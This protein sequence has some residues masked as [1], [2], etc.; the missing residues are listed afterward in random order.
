MAPSYRVMFSGYAPV[1][2]A[3]FKPLYDRLVARDDIDMV[4]TGGLRTKNESGEYEYDAAGMFAPFGIDPSTVVPVSDIGD[5]TCD[6]LFAANTKM[7]APDEVR[8]KIQIFHGISFRNRAVRAENAHADYYFIVGPYMRRRF[9]DAGIMNEDDPRA[10]PIGFMKTDR[11]LDG[12]LD[13]SALLEQ[14]GFD[15]SRPVVVYAPTGQKRNSLET[16]GEEVIRRLRDSGEV[17]ILV[18]PHDHPKNKT[19]DWFDHLS[20][21]EDAHTRITRDPD[22]IPMLYMADLL[23]TD[24]SSVS[25]EYALMD[26]PMVFL[27]VPKL[28]AKSSKQEASM[29]DLDTWGRKGGDLVEQPEDVVNVVTHA[30]A[31]PQ[32]HADVR[33]AMVDDLFFHPGAAT[34]AAETWFDAFLNRSDTSASPEAVGVGRG[35]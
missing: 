32:E 18:K 3:C 27:D 25:N 8:A 34:T 16:M 12:S 11:L 33:K 22:V 35:A 6:A 19:V 26:R 4:L 7:M 14:Y 10:L 30:L 2:F 13:R 29:I 17:S 24:A 31:N 23:M 5:M 15:G 9:R 20:Q 1:H 21:Y 28:I